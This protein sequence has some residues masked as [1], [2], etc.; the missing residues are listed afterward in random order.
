MI[1]VTIM[2]RIWQNCADDP[3]RARKL[4][5]WKD[6]YINPITERMRYLLEASKNKVIHGTFDPAEF[7][8]AAGKLGMERAKAGELIGADKDLFSN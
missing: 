5:G 6:D 3:D 1:H 4:A 7:A 2:D 8:A